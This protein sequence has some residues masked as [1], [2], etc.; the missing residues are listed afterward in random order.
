MEKI[1]EIAKLDEITKLRDKSER[2]IKLVNAIEKTFPDWLDT[3][4]FNYSLTSNAKILEIFVAPNGVS[5]VRQILPA[6]REAIRPFN[7]SQIKIKT[8]VK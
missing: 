8:F 5:Q 3:T 2:Y 7:V 6:M 1:S 4:Q